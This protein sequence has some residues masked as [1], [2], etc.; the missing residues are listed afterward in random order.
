MLRIQDGL[1]RPF[2]PRRI[3]IKFILRDGFVLII[4]QDLTSVS[5]RSILRSF[6]CRERVSISRQSGP[7]LESMSQALDLL[8][9][10]ISVYALISEDFDHRTS[11]LDR[12]NRCSFLNLKDKDAQLCWKPLSSVARW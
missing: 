12:F 2:R 3:S 4:G 5:T 7:K 9:T 11:T 1:K 8:N 6:F 10:G